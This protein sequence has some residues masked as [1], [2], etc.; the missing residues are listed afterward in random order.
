MDDWMQK[1]FRTAVEGQMARIWIPTIF[2]IANRN[3]FLKLSDRLLEQGVRTLILDFAACAYADSSGLGA[4]ITLQ[5]RVAMLEGTLLLQNLNNDDLSDLFKVTQ[6]DTLFE[7]LP[8]EQFKETCKVLIPSFDAINNEL[9]EYFARNPERLDALE[10]RTFELLLEAVFKNNGFVTQVG[11]G[12]ADGG[13][14]LRLVHTDVCGD[15]ITLV[16]AKKYRRDRSIRIE[17]V[18]AFTAV[19]EEEKANRGLFVT[20]S[21]YLPSAKLFAERQ[22]HRLTLADS[23]DVAKWCQIALQN[24]R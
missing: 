20:T 6:L 4:L 1:E 10:W 19:V 15:L 8:P 11:P 18:Q 21:R 2:I 24:Q 22:R 3:D 5:R 13:I 17:A 9:I 16:Q 12:R 23:V 14:D 7:F